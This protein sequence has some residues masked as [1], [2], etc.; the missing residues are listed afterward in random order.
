MIYTEL[1]IKQM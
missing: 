1:H